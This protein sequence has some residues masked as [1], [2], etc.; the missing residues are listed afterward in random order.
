MEGSLAG[1]Y[2]N[3]ITWALVPVE[4]AWMSESEVAEE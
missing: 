1:E 4:D 3:D 2:L